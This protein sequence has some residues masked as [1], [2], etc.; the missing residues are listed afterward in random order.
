MNIKK[1]IVTASTALSLLIAAATVYGASDDIAATP[2][3]VKSYARKAGNSLR[4]L[5]REQREAIFAEARGLLFMSNGTDAYKKTTSSDLVE[6]KKGKKVIERTRVPFR[7][8]NQ[9]A[10]FIGSD[11][12]LYDFFATIAHHNQSP[13]ATQ[14]WKQAKLYIYRAGQKAAFASFADDLEAME[15]QRGIYFLRQ[16]PPELR[17]ALFAEMLG[18]LYLENGR[19][20][21]TGVTKY[22]TISGERVPYQGIHKGTKFVDAMGTVHDFE[23][24]RS[25]ENSRGQSW[26]TWWPGVKLNI[27]RA[28]QDK[29][30]TPFEEEIKAMREHASK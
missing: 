10:Q 9:G 4:N 15:V 24:V 8:V 27:H 23:R 7:Q 3:N 12:K 18:L 11:G 30:F 1:V 14:L 25:E 28:G 6:I 16:M 2:G 5:S 26:R 19:E 29:I 17:G 20:A 22:T 13:R 21:Y